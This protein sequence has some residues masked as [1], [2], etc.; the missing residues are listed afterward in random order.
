MHLPHHWP[1]LTAAGQAVGAGLLKGE[2]AVGI[3]VQAA[4][5]GEVAG[6]E[7]GWWVRQGRRT[8]MLMGRLVQAGRD[9]RCGQ[10]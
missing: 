7:R 9:P 4:E 8:Q 3:G 6:R 10:R 5:R 2:E 1:P